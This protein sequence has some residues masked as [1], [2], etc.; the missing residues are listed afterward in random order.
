MAPD[1]PEREEGL[2]RNAGQP[3]LTPLRPPPPADPSPAEVHRRNQRIGIGL[4]VAAAVLIGVL[5]M[6]VR[7][8]YAHNQV[9]WS[10]MDRDLAAATAPSG[11]T[12]GSTDHNGRLCWLSPTCERPTAG[13]RIVGTSNVPPVSC[14]TAE[15]IARTWQG[16]I[17]TNTLRD[18]GSCSFEGNIHGR[19]ASVSF[20]GGEKNIQTGQI[21]PGAVS[22]VIGLAPSMWN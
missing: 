3:D 1:D 4:S 16:F 8:A 12:L 22:V 14:A 5:A 9:P 6:V 15:A 13:R 21:Y 2:G 10:A 20:Y 18:S 19:P 17:I 7:D 11:Y